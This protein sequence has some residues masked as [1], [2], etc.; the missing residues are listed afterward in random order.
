[1]IIV[2]LHHNVIAMVNEINHQQSEENSDGIKTMFSVSGRNQLQ[3]I[4]IADNKAN[5]IT[6]LC[7]ILIFLIVALFG[8]GILIGD[9]GIENNLQFI[10]PLSILLVFCSVSAV[11][12]IMALKPKIIRSKKSDRSALFFHNYYRKTLD[13]YKGQMH[14]IMQSNEKIYNQMLTDMYYNGLV[15]ERKYTLLSFA[16]TLFLLALVLSVT[17]YII[18]S[19]I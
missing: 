7:T 17:A 4:A 18:A 2:I 5:M 6:G 12:A 14:S 16:Y 19:V 1:M 3:L 13:E 10:L 15:L 8:S 11:C 9:S